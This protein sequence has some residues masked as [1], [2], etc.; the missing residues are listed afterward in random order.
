MPRL[1]LYL[2]I[3]SFSLFFLHGRHFEEFDQTFLEL[4]TMSSLFLL[5]LVL[6]LLNLWLLLSSAEQLLYTILI[7]LA[8]QFSPDIHIRLPNFYLIFILSIPGPFLIFFMHN[9]GLFFFF[10]LYNSWHFSLFLVPTSHRRS[11]QFRKWF[12]IDRLF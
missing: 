10:P 6:N 4:S 2:T 3:F 12:H 8:A 11:Y 5:S 1:R 7:F 9:S